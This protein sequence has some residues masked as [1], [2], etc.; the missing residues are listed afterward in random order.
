MVYYHKVFVFFHEIVG[1]KLRY[2]VVHFIYI[3]IYIHIISIDTR[4]RTKA[5][6]FII[7]SQNP[8]S[9]NLFLNCT[10]HWTIVK[11]IQLDL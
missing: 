10:M 3:Y 8:C 1:I 7:L 2:F 4:Y 6:E 5:A 9:L 11:T